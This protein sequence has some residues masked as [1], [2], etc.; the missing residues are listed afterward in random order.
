MQE[1]LTRFSSGEE[2]ANAISHLIGAVLSLAALIIM[3]VFS[4]IHGNAWHVVSSAVFGTTMLMLYLSSTL[5][6]WLP[7]GKAKEFF[8]T[9]DQIAIFLLIAGTY[10]PLSLIA[11]HGTMGWIIF[12]IEWGL[13]FIG[14]ITKLFKQNK[15]ETGV[16][17]FYIILYV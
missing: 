16:N 12:G 1:K 8:F 11:L 4:A 2:L 13:A 5:N 10:T 7:A 15:F 9:F 17:I 6:H 3:V 14:I